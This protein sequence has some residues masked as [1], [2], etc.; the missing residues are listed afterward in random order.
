MIVKLIKVGK[1]FVEK[2]LEILF[3]NYVVCN[4]ERHYVPVPVTD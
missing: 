2:L 1:N 4:I 3:S